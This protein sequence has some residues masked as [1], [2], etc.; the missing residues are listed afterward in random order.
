MKYNAFHSLFRIL[1]FLFSCYIVTKILSNGLLLN[2]VPS[3]VSLFSR[4]YVE[5]IDSI[6]CS[7]TGTFLE[8][9]QYRSTIKTLESQSDAYEAEFLLYREEL[10]KQKFVIDNQLSKVLELQNNSVKTISDSNTNKIFSYVTVVIQIIN[11]STS[12]YNQMYGDSL[13]QEDIRKDILDLKTLLTNL[14]R[15]SREPNIIIGSERASA[16][17]IPKGSMGP[18]E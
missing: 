15:Q 8:M 11:V 4:A 1:I 14:T 5:A 7:M 10:Q 13:N 3:I 12:I 16:L 17:T 18:I 2:T 6:F 9:Q